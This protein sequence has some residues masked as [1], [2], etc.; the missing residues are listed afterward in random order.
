MALEQCPVP[1]CLQLIHAHQRDEHMNTSILHHIMS[2]SEGYSRLERLIQHQNEKI[3]QQAI[4]I[5]H[6]RAEI[7]QLRLFSNIINGVLRPDC[8]FDSASK[9]AHIHLSPDQMEIHD[10]DEI[11]EKSYALVRQTMDQGTWVWEMLYSKDTIND[12]GVC[13]GVGLR[14]VLDPNYLT[15]ESLMLVRM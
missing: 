9:S 10:E 3:D 11:S 1:Q 4:I 7:R 12:E 14:P 8:I 15:S 5:E 6:Q 2:L 13:F